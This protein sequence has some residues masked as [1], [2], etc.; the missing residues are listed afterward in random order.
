[1][2]L[3]TPPTHSTTS[4][5]VAQSL[6]SNN[7]YDIE[8][9]GYLSNHAKHAIVALDKLGAPD[10]RI[11]DYWDQYTTLT[12]Y[13]LQLHKVDIADWG[14][15][16][17]DN[18]ND[19]NWKEWRG[20]KK[21]WQEM[22]QYLNSKDKPYDVL[23]KEY[24]PDLLTGI[25]GALTHGIIHLGWGIDAQNSWMTMEG[26][27]YLNFCY[28]PMAPLTQ[29]SIQDESNAVESALRI[30]KQWID[31][32]LQNTW[33][34]PTK[35]KYD[36]TFHP[37]LVPAGFQW[38]LAKVLKDAH[39][40]VTNLPSW[41]R[42]MPL[43]EVWKE[44]Y[45]FVVVTYLS[46]RNPDIAK[47]DS[48]NFVV[49][50]MITS[51]WALENVCNVID[52]DETTRQAL[53]QFWAVGVCLL[54]TAGKYP[55]P[56]QLRATSDE[57][58]HDQAFDDEDFDWSPIVQRGCAETEEHNIKLVYVCQALWNRYNRWKGFS[59][60]ASSFTLTPNIGPQQTAFE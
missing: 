28:V 9:N 57:L 36:E 12:P 19:D 32:D 37:E 24:A 51:L 58:L 35:K 43:P 46:T 50:H 41:L 34:E 44:M 27:A 7:I 4:S 48:G 56:K 38:H 45:R 31:D 5:A 8:F 47:R 59:E 25:A 1:M 23:V 30:S 11:Q 33:I 18:I 3:P 16:T 52:D 39:P 2:K 14:S 6:L 10:Q 20:Q 13:N 42:N 55:T 15:I 17:T 60:A 29:N 26:L 21:H 40:V 53:E 54:G 22:V 49:L